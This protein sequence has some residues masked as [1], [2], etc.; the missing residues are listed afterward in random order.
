M[1]SSK[2]GLNSVSDC[3]LCVFR[4]RHSRGNLLIYSTGT[5][6][7]KTTCTAS[8]SG[9]GDQKNL[10]RRACDSIDIKN[11]GIPISSGNITVSN[12]KDIITNAVPTL[13]DLQ[14]TIISR[15]MDL[16]LSQWT[17][18]TD[19]ILQVGIPAF[20]I[21]QGVAAMENAKSVG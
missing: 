8:G 12:P 4:F 9:G 13:G 15:Q 1:A 21:V 19:D 10:D 20:L 17:G 14:T 2:V 18:P 16:A 6:E 7:D 5:T 11:V 3:H